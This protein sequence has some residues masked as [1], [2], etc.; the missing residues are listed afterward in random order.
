LNL[1][2]V[3]LDLIG[4]HKLSSDGLHVCVQTMPIIIAKLLAC[5]MV[6]RARGPQRSKLQDQGAVINPGGDRGETGQL[7][8]LLCL[9]HY[10]VY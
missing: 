6:L 9:V 4:V 8:V 3:K 10:L 2:K 1:V 7:F 5:I